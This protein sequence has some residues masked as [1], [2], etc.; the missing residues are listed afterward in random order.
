ME[1]SAEKRKNVCVKRKDSLGWAE[2]FDRKKR[3][4]NL[5]QQNPSKMKAGERKLEKGSR[6][7]GGERVVRLLNRVES[8]G[9]E[10][11]KAFNQG[12]GG[13]TDQSC[14]LGEPKKAAS[15]AD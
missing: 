10:A 11:R 9:G 15:C 14:P 12:E 1:Q 2:C 8:G 7:D 3:Q 6:R 4:T 5:Q 13:K